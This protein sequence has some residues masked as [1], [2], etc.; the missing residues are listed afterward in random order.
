M[1]RVRLRRAIRPRFFPRI[2]PGDGSNRIPERQRDGDSAPKTPVDCDRRRAVGPAGAG[3]TVLVSTGPTGRRGA[4]RRWRPPGA[5]ILSPV[6]QAG[7]VGKV[8][9]PGGFRGFGVVPPV[10]VEVKSAEFP[11]AVAFL[12]PSF[13]PLALASLPC[14]ECPPMQSGLFIVAEKFLALSRN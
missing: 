14:Q 10:P 11:P 7:A 6:I 4:N 8:A 3:S 1:S 2:R 5:G 9:R 13:H 12:L